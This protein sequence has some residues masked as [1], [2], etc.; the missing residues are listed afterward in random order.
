MRS[1]TT[2][3]PGVIA[4]SLLLVIPAACQSASSAPPPPRATDITD[5]NG[6]TALVGGYSGDGIHRYTADDLLSLPCSPRDSFLPIYF[7]AATLVRSNLG[8]IG[9]RCGVDGACEM[10]P[11]E[12]EA[13][14]HRD[15]YIRSVGH[16]ADGSPI[17]LRITNE[18]E[19]RSWRP[20]LNGGR[21]RSPARPHV[22]RRRHSHT[23]NLC[24]LHR[25]ALRAGSH[26]AAADR[27]PS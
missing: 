2:A 5:I 15:I 26:T 13:A 9:G 14:G 6:F 22:E 8:G 23:A 21:I 18:S 20:D 4:C 16:L 11:D 25:I 27:H 7:D 19:F 3:A 10:T 17:D 1:G 12:I 24:A